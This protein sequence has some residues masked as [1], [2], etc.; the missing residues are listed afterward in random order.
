MADVH[1]TV[2]DDTGGDDGSPGSAET[3]LLVHGSTTWGTDPVLGF[4]AQR[5]LARSG[6]RVLVMDRRGCGSSPDIDRG[7]YAV[8]ARDIAGLLAEAGGAHLVGHSY[9]G[10]AAMFAAASAPHLVRSLTLIEPGC[11]QAAA[12]D[13]VVA[14][15]IAANREGHAKL[16]M[17]LPAR[18]YLRGATDSV[19]LPPLPATPERLRAAATALREKPCWQ[20]PVPVAAL[21]AAKW[22]KL[23]I[24]G[25]WE[26]APAL[27]RARGGEPLIAC[28]RVTAERIGAR[29]LTVPSAHHYPHV[30]SPSAV[31]AALC[32]TFASGA[33]ASRSSGAC[34]NSAASCLSRAAW[35]EASRLPAALT[36]LSNAASVPA[37]AAAPG[38][39]A[40]ASAFAHSPLA[41][42]AWP[43]YSRVR[44]HTALGVVP[45]VMRAGTIRHSWPLPAGSIQSPFDAAAGACCRMTAC[46]PVPDAVRT[47][48]VALLTIT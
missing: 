19:G 48:P 41:P 17:D 21:R 28:A 2:W 23:V 1:V 8:D 25:T 37:L 14:A 42:F 22:P 45:A 27:Y 36:S 5:S 31:N 3:V 18:V 24:R 7:D 11:Y 46:A 29:L 26:T 32:R 39:A 15:A 30:D 40:I 9:G 44:P 4:G 10:V 20:A 33:P 13:P 34:Y 38:A 47:L 12:G 35:S 6:Y 16:P 43:R